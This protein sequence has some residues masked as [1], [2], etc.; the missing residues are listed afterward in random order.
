MRLHW[1]PLAGALLAGACG[2]DSPD[3]T[4]KPAAGEVL[5]VLATPFVGED[6]AMVVRIIGPVDT[7]LAAGGYAVASSRTGN[8]SRAVVT[9]NIEAGNLLR[10][11]VPDVGN[12]SGYSAFVEQAASRASYALLDVSG[13]RLELRKP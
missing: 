11:R 12:L 10:I 1:V 2:G 13:Y 5:V 9:G 4:P 6:G 7:V 3:P 8:I